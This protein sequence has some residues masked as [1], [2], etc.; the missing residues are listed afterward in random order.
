MGETTNVL[1]V[2]ARTAATPA[3]VD[4]VRDRASRGKCQ[5]TLLVPKVVHGLAKVADPEGGSFD[6]SEQVL[7]LAIPLL[8]EAAG[9]QVDGKIGDPVP[10][11]AVEDAVTFG[12]YDEIILS[13]LP[14]HVSHWL[15]LDLPRKVADLGLPVTTLT[16]RGKS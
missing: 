4:A 15:H 8:E 14:K 7:E 6:E 2:A 1:V 16:A 9:G 11:N 13:T 3:L 10:L 12:N 5:F